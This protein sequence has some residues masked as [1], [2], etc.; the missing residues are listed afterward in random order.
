MKKGILRRSLIVIM[1][2]ICMLGLMACDHGRVDQNRF[3]VDLKAGYGNTIEIGSYAPFYVEI[4]NNGADFEGSVQ[5]IIPGRVGNNVMYEKELSLQAGSKKTVELVGM[6]DM[7]TRQ[8][9]IRVA[10]TK[11]NVIWSS[12]ENCTT[13]ADL[14]DV[15]VGILSDDY[16]ALGY[17]DHKTFSSSKELTTQIYELTKDSF[18]TDWHALEMLD[19][20]VISDFSTDILS[21]EQINALGLWVSDGGLLMVGTGSTSNKTLA[22]L[23]GR[24]FDVEIGELTSYETKFGLTVADYTYDYAYD[25]P[26]YSP[27]EDDTYTTFYEQ[28]YEDLREWLE[29]EFMDQFKDDYYYDDQYDTWDEY[30]EDSFYWYCYD[31]FYSIYLESINAGS[32]GYNTM[33]EIPYVK[34]DVLELSGSLLSDPSTL[35][36]EGDRKD[37]RTYDLAYAIEQGDGYILLSSI[38]FTKTPFSSFEGNSTMFIHWVETLIGQK[39]YEEAMNYSDYSYGYYNPY[40]IN[41]DEEEIFNGTASAT[42]PPVLVYILLI[43][44][45]I[46]A[47]LVVYLVLRHKK[48]TMKLWLL[49]PIV[50]AGLSIIIFCIGFSTRIYRPVINATTLITPNGSASVQETYVTVT[51]PENKSYDVGFS[52]SQGVEY[53]NLDYDYYYYDD[54]EEIDW[55]SYSIG[56]KYGYESVDVTLGEHEAMA[57]VNFK[58]DSVVADSGNVII[59]VNGPMV[60][61]ITVSNAYGCDLEDAALIIDGKVYVIGDIKQGSTIE[62]SRLKKEDEMTLY[63]D[64]LGSIILQDESMKGFLGFMLGSISSTYDEYLC[65]LRALNS[66]SDYVDREASEIV[67]VAIPSESSAA[68]LQGATDYN[69]RRVEIIYVESNFPAMGW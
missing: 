13:S 19:V 69:E 20:I 55:D 31:N 62:G 49:Y 37:G 25:T 40:D 50:A 36:F 39:C 60:S 42:V 3:D 11:G 68:K 35:V 14:S 58:L 45:Y 32:G 63:R 17:M 33:D 59:R 53:M 38:D 4:T 64:G 67:F 28:N 8:V 51:V 6:I 16:S 47:I 23:N 61:D 56:Y 41:Y 9:N 66:M 7:V 12:L 65:K 26:T 44:A 46:I 21:E 54:E 52:P 27:Y 29:E 1:V 22:S 2:A 24:F 57:G 15:N 10:D 18:P 34:A 43:L 30:W 48:K 5:M